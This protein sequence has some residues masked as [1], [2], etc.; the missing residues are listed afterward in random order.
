MPAKVFTCIHH[1]YR[2]TRN[3]IH[4]SWLFCLSIFHIALPSLS[5]PPQPLRTDCRSYLHPF[6]SHTLFVLLANHKILRFAIEKA[7]PFL[8]PDV[9][10]ASQRKNDHGSEVE[11]QKHHTLKCI[12]HKKGFPAIHMNY[13]KYKNFYFIISFMNAVF[14]LTSAYHETTLIN[15]GSHLMSKFPDE[16]VCFEHS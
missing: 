15:E 3:G 16:R 2:T 8:L 5:A 13:R 6:A 14:L 9:I 1:I 4:R 12:R 10:P 7:V 11:P